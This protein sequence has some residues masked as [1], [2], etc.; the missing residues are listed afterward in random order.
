M[1]RTAEALREIRGQPYRLFFLGAAVHAAIHVGLWTLLL[2]TGMGARPDN[3]F[4]WHGYEMLFGFAGAVVT[5]FLLTASASWT[6]RRTLAPALLPVLFAAWL[7]ARVN[8]LAAGSA[9]LTLAADG[10]VLWGLAIALT[11]VLV[12]AR[13]RRN[14]RFIPIVVLLA[15]AASGAQLAAAGVIPDWRYPL[16]QGAADL[17]LIL[18]VIMGG[19]VIPFFTA[20]RLPALDVQDP[21]WLGH[22]ASA[23]VVLSVVAVWTLP[24][25]VAAM[26]TWFAACTLL[27]R[28]LHWAPWGTRREPLLWILH[29]GYL[30]LVIALFLRGGALAWGWLPLS[31]TLHAVVVGGLGCLTL[32]MMARVPLGHGGHALRAAPWLIPAFVLVGLA[33]VPRLLAAWPQFIHPDIAY[34][35]AGAAWALAFVIYAV[36]YSPILLGRRRADSQSA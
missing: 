13:S 32:G 9:W 12:A 16:L 35:L 36:G 22:G 23:L 18:M 4:L 5:G 33:A 27:A 15:A 21:D 20:R 14:Y 19:R 26:I 3:P 30:W 28:L 17:L 1:S 34:G 2:T 7:V 24:A 10:V 8:A 25:H 11:R 31:T 29:L 6:G